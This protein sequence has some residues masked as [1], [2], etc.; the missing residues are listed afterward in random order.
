MH[1][2][3]SLLILIV[4]YFHYVHMAYVPEGL[5][6][7]VMLSVFSLIGS[8]VLSYIFLF[9]NPGKEVKITTSE[10]RKTRLIIIVIAG[11]CLIM[12]L[13]FFSKTFSNLNIID[14]PSLV[15]Y[16]NDTEHGISRIKL[17]IALLGAI[18]VYSH[19]LNMKS[20]FILNA[21]I[22]CTQSIILYYSLTNWNISNR[23]YNEINPFFSSTNGL[24]SFAIV[25]LSYSILSI[26]PLTERL[27]ITKG[28]F[29]IINLNL[30]ISFIIII[31]SFSRGGFIAVGIMMFY[32]IGSS[33]FFQKL[34]HFTNRISK[35]LI[36]FLVIGVSHIII[37][38]FNIPQITIYFDQINKARN[39]MFHIDSRFIIWEGAI[40]QIRASVGTFFFGMR[41]VFSLL[42]YITHHAHNS[43]IEMVR[44]AGIFS[45]VIFFTAICIALFRKRFDFFS[46]NVLAT[47]VLLMLL[48]LIVG[49]TDL[50]WPNLFCFPVF[51]AMLECCRP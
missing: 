22:V 15:W 31:L 32:F 20:V 29:S 45:F 17:F 5:H 12:F 3:F 34:N 8:V 51:W 2:L 30:L 13:A 47:G 50:L 9:N 28:L 35:L 24:T 38:P 23:L 25:S 37:N 11:Y 36:L 6:R 18:F 33:L 43:Y 19:K 48:I 46:K 21:I 4:F 44:N 42:L 40:D 41:E 16:F 10:D 14:L 26:S 27:K 39:L 49:E 7:G 1:Q